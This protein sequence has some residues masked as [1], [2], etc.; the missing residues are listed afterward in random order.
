MR[1]LR[2]QRGESI[3]E[4]LF[5]LLIA[6]LGM[7]LLAGA[8][9]AA[10]R[11]NRAAEQ[12]DR[13]GVPDTGDTATVTIAKSTEQVVS[14]VPDRSLWSDTPCEVQVSVTGYNKE[15]LYFYE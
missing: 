15:G 9:V 3:A 6:A 5:A 7:I 10:A 4:T 8:L 2:S 14:N 12:A 13:Y 11:V 1:K